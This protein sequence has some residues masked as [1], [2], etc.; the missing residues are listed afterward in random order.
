M[1][2]DILGT[3]EITLTDKGRD[4]SAGRIT[5][6]DH[7]GKLV[8]VDAD[9]EVAGRPARVEVDGET[10]R[11][12]LLSP[13]SSRG[14]VHH[15]YEIVLQGPDAFAGTRRRGMLARVPVSAQRVLGALDVAP[16][17]A[18]GEPSTALVPI[19]ANV[20]EAKARAAEAAERASLAAAE[21]AAALAEVEAVTA[22]DAARR[23]A[24]RATAARAAIAAEHAPASLAADAH[25]PVPQEL[26]AELP[27]PTEPPA[28]VP[29]TVVGAS[30]GTTSG[31]SRTRLLP[32]THRLTHG[33]RTVLAA[34]AFPGVFV[35][36]PSFAA[37]E[38]RLRA[39]GWT[40]TAISTD[41]VIEIDEPLLEH[42]SSVRDSLVA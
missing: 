9:P 26:L 12:E 40:V 42:A 25:R 6:R 36:G 20:A 29:T 15:S 11:F 18:S 41:D 17:A 22:M 16:E 37:P 23:A 28:F 33:D 34:V 38:D 8:V 32:V 30:A 39:A 13:G 14:S 21:A 24:E 2:R 1:N 4:A 19:S 10:V 5:F 3:W 7:E 27:A 35:W 31:G